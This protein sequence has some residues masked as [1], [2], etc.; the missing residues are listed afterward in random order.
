MTFK[1]TKIVINSE[2][3]CRYKNH[4]LYALKRHLLKFE[5][6]YPSDIEPVGYVK[7][8]PVFPRSSVTTLRS[9]NVWFKEAKCVRVGE[10]PYNI[11]KARPKWDKV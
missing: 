3:I 11:V 6:I 1:S 5:V 4:P 7:G 2:F 9:R 10:K 8:E